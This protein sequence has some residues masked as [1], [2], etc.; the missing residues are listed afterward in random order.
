MTLSDHVQAWLDADGAF[1]AGLNLYRQTGGIKSIGYYEKF[2]SLRYLPPSAKH[3]LRRDLQRYLHNNPPTIA[4]TAP[5]APQE[6]TGQAQEPEEPAAIVALRQNTIPL[7]KRY[8]HLKAELYTHAVS[9]SP[10]A[11]LL[12]ELSRE[13]M[14]ETIP[15]LDSIYDQIREFQRT[16]EVPHMPRPALVQQTV[17]KM[18]SIASLRS[19]ISNIRRKMKREKLSARELQ[20]YETEIAEKEASIA[21]LSAELGID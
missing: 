18:K 8:S 16:G 21:E 11:N 10:D 5:P 15:H 19:R 7:H 17:K 1:T 3:H 2:L 14:A 12:Y 6:R 13:I 20:Q 9:E 4:G